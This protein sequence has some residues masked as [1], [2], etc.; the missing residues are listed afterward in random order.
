MLFPNNSLL[1]IT[2][3]NF[4]STVHLYSPL[5]NTIGTI[6]GNLKSLLFTSTFLV[7]FKTSLHISVIY[8]N[9]LIGIL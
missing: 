2:F 3:L 9:N 5:Y 6:A 1:L 7:F 4:F 8:K